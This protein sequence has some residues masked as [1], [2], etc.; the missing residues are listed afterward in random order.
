MI[1]ILLKTG[2]VPWIYFKY[3][4]WQ[5]PER[6]SDLFVSASDWPNLAGRLSRPLWGISGHLQLQYGLRPKLTCLTTLL[7]AAGSFNDGPAVGGIIFDRIFDLLCEGRRAINWPWLILGLL[8]V[9]PSGSEIVIFNAELLGGNN[10]H[11]LFKR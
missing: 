9:H 8:S 6:K 2:S 3:L 4:A 7:R 5:P 1:I 11:G 10:L